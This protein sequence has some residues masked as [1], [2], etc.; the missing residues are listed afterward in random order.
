MRMRFTYILQHE[1]AAQTPYLLPQLIET[2]ADPQNGEL[3]LLGRTLGLC[4]LL[5][6]EKYTSHVTLVLQF[7]HLYEL[8]YI[9]M[10]Y[11]ESILVCFCGVMTQILE[12]KCSGPEVYSQTWEK[13]FFNL[14]AD[15]HSRA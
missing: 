9:L 6:C 15:N 1:A 8:G 4:A 3:Q 7:S 2:M 10:H 14:H 11:N 13:C 12:A 5:K